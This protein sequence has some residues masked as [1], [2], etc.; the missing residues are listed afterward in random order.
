MKITRMEI[1]VT[2]QTP[3]PNPIRDALQSL[4]GAGSVR[5][6]L[7]TDATH[8]GA[9]I[10]GSGDASFGRIGGGPDALAALIK[11]ELEPLVVGT[12][13]AFVAA[14]HEAMV[15]ETEYH[16]TA[17]LA[18]FGIAAIDTALWDCQGKA[19]GVPCWQLWGGVHT[20]IP[21]YAMVGWLN[22]GLDTLT[23]IAS[24]AVAQGFRG[25]K[26]KVG[27]ATL[28]EDIA[29]VEAVRKAIGDSVDLMVDANQ[30]LSTAEAIRR[31]RAFQELGCLWWEEPIA[32][33]DIDGYRGTGS[34]TR[35][36]RR[37]RG[38]PLH[39]GRLCALPAARCRRHHPP[40]LRRAG[41]PTAMLQIGTT[42][43][44]RRPYASHGGGPVQL[45][46]MA[47]PAQ[48]D[49]SGDGAY[50]ERLALRP[51][52]WVRSHPSGARVLLGIVTG[53]RGSGTNKVP[54]LRTRIN[55]TTHSG[56]SA[57]VRSDV[58]GAIGVAKPWTHMDASWVESTSTGNR[59]GI[60]NTAANLGQLTPGCRG[61]L[62]S[63][64][65]NGVQ[66]RLG[67]GVEGVVEDVV[68]ARLFYHLSQ[69]HHN[70]AVRHLRDDPQVVG[71]EH[72]RSC[73]IPP[74]TN[75]SGAGS[76]LSR[77]VQRRGRLIGNQEIGMAGKCHRDHGAL[78]IPP[79]SWWG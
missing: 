60:G 61:A 56:R 25:V 18:T 39:A 31:G 23:D 4:P 15:R 5:V 43:A 79:L 27:A 64:P 13:P 72:D 50:R 62:A 69:V 78:D 41:G 63:Q 71:D 20:Q 49:L 47:Q 14:T 10:W 9:T 22:Y 42:A 55:G 6:T 68:D 37:D 19:L 26:I 3:N 46:V 7:H 21:A 66:Q 34:G 44:A 45:N 48:R 8:H 24:M 77:H 28:K 59:I 38:E 75:A 33:D 12:D 53:A 16:G 29:R 57:P 2:H 70:H 73:R 11:H 1:T 74:A 17:G 35:Y 51:H 36:S 40:D 30:S 67:I 32:A 76:V 52:R 58:R 65:G 54:A